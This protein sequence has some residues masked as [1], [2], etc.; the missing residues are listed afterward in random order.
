MAQAYTPGL[1]VSRSKRYRTRRVLPISGEVLVDV[2]DQVQATDVVARAELPGDVLPVNLANILSAPPG[3]IPNLM[4]K[5][6]GDRV[7][8]GDVIAR[9]K[10][11]FG[12]FKTEYV[13]KWSGTIETISNITGQMLIR[14]EPI[15][16]EVHAFAT[17]QVIE[18]LTDE[19]CVV[20]AQVTF[21]QG[22][23]G[24]GGEAF[25]PIRMACTKN[26][27]EFTPDLITPDMR[28]QIV[29]GGARVPGETVQRAIETGVS[30]IVS[31]GIDDADLREILGYDLGVAITGTEQIGL[32]LVITE[33][34]GEIAMAKKTFELLGSREGA[35]AAING[36]TQIRAGVIRPEIIIP[37]ES[38]PDQDEPTEPPSAVL[39]V[40]APV[41][42]IRDPYFG[43]LGTVAEL[44]S[45]PQVLGSGSKA[46]VVE[47]LTE[48]GEQVMV[49]R[50]NV[51]IV[52]G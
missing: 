48:S 3:D 8:V 30:A 27:Q 29:I 23:F 34:F 33:G 5:H 9:T 47:V 2:G 37:L 17:G 15:P 12:L 4:L 16:V 43:I 21:I 22:I 42:I 18:R 38:A 36:A 6:E 14:G 24:I 35:A 50:A 41:R 19:G 26:T 7:E 31:G 39:E 25:G 46:R 44:P 52:S 20:E 11:I 28:G 45:E 51:E 49:P 32:T 1:E 40:G 13:S 10:G